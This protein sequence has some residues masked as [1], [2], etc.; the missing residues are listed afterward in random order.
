MWFRNFKRQYEHVWVQ[1]SEIDAGIFKSHLEF[2]VQAWDETDKEF[3]HKPYSSW[4]LIRMQQDMSDKDK[5]LVEI[6]LAG[7]NPQ[8]M[9]E[10]IE[11]W[12]EDDELEIGIKFA[13]FSEVDGDE[14]LLKTDLD[15]DIPARLDI[16]AYKPFLN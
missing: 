4:N 13:Y 9:Q 15:D 12:L 10:E 2:K 3:K 6:P 14:Y 11:S 7:L 16:E 5:Y 8:Q 1:I